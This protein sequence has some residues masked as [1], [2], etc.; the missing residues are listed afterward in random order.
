[1]QKVAG[2]FLELKLKN[3]LKIKNL[4]HMTAKVR[5]Q[6]DVGCTQ[7]PI[8]TRLLKARMNPQNISKF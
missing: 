2:Y 6:S 5:P 3:N 4:T 8:H 7:I 1:M